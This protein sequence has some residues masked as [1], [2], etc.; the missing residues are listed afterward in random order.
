MKTKVLVAA[1]ACL[2][3]MAGA[4]QADKKKDQAVKSEVKSPRD[5]ATGQ[6]SGRK[7][8]Q[9]TDD[10]ASSSDTAR[11]ASSGMA[12]GKK[13]MAQ[14]DWHA[15]ATT[16]TSGDPHVQNVAATPD[17]A[18]AVRESPSKASLGVRESPT[19][20]ST[21]K[22]EVRESPSKASLGK[23]SVATGDLDGD[24]R[25]DK[26]AASDGVKSPRD[27]ATGQA[28]GKRQHGAVNV[29]EQTEKSPRN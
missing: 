29:K 3:L 10:G 23:T 5:L 22:T 21:G 19:K 8:N 1:V 18:T 25:A 7:T 28:S 17:D 16:K 6:A 2:S 20:A 24:G 14:D 11:E 9:K 13:T 4:Q 12:T 27:V 26:A 15:Q